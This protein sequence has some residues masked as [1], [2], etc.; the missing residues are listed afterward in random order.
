[1]GPLELSTAELD[2]L[3]AVTSR[4]FALAI[5]L[6]PEPAR[7]QVGIAYLLFR[8]ADTFEDSDL[9]PQELQLAALEL[10]ADLV[11][12]PSP[13][14]ATRAAHDWLADP[15]SRHEGYLDLLAATPGVLAACMALE[16]RARDT[17]R[18]SVRRTAQG[19]AGF[20]ARRREG[21][22]LGL[23]DLR[24]YCY[25]VAGLVGE[26]L[27][28]LFLL[29]RGHLAGVA[30]FLRQRAAR[31]GE[32]LQLVNIL[33][34]SMVDAHEG[35]IYL[36]AACERSEVLTLARDGLEEAHE[37]V[38]AL[39]HASA[40][41]DLVAFNALLVR[42]AAATLDRLEAAG[43]GAKL[44]RGEVAAIVADLQREL[45]LQRPVSR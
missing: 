2:R 34:D 45:A 8:I 41:R 5:P 26:M 13:E 32:A 37:Y 15:P 19:M 6:L 40:P 38:L 22:P 9:W 44:S 7:R 27:T 28:E 30:P 36:P 39:Q 23:A 29:D 21:G 31:F 10:F 35:R 17:I 20:V 14:A 18:D 11:R 33:K 4:T 16:P 24:G 43:P 12:E 42:L 3:L 25:V 1:M